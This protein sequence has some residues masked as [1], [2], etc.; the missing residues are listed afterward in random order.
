[1][2]IWDAEEDL[3]EELGPLVIN[4]SESDGVLLDGSG[5]EDDDNNADEDY[6]PEQHNAEE[7]VN[8]DFNVQMIE[9]TP[10]KRGK[11][12]SFRFSS[13]VILLTITAF[14]L[15]MWRGLWLILQ[16]AGARALARGCK[17]KR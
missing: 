4:F 6:N 16:S 7:E 2:D 5:Y 10:L 9:E 13:H 8:K 17:P 3:V 12:V 15:S 11:K 1:M 14:S